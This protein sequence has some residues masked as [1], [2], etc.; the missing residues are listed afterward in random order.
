MVEMN[1]TG[2]VLEIL[3]QEM[4]STEIAYFFL[5]I[6]AFYDTR[7]E[8]R[9]DVAKTMMSASQELYE[10]I[11]ERAKAMSEASEFMSQFTQS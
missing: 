3:P 1:K 7:Q 8:V 10:T 5:S 6:L 2:Q 11:P 4:T 9:E